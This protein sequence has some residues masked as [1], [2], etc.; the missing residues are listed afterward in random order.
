MVIKTNHLICNGDFYTRHESVWK[1]N[2]SKL[3]IVCGVDLY[4]D[5]R[6]CDCV[7]SLF[8]I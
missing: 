3:N 8:E 1:V 6:V 4:I 7:S 2:F 5:E